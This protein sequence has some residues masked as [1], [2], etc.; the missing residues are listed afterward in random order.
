MKNLNGKE[1]QIRKA[2]GLQIKRQ[3]ESWFITQEQ[4]AEYA[5]VTT[6]QMSAVVNGRTNYTLDTLTKIVIANNLEISLSVEVFK[7]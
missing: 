2:I 6:A 5:G 7:K 3:L 1:I 4:A